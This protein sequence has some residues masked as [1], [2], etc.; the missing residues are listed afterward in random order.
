MGV[1]MGLFLAACFASAGSTAWND[2]EFGKL[3][4]CA[5]TTAALMFLSGLR[6]RMRR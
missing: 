4:R 2:G 3:A 1:W 5:A 6:L